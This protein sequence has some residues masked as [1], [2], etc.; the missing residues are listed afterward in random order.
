MAI[1]VFES[2]DGRQV[3]KEFPLAQC[4][5]EIRLRGEVYRKIIVGAMPLKAALPAY[6]TA[7]GTDSESRQAAY[8]KSD[9][10][11]EKRKKI[12]ERGGTVKVGHDVDA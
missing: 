5:P 3:E 9:K 11:Y 4:P 6:M 10:W 1:Y 2:A 12:E 8:L 7:A